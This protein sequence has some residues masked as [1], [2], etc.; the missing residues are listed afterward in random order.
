VKDKFVDNKENF[1]E[2]FL[3]MADNKLHKSYTKDINSQQGIFL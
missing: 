3:I 2:K 1:K